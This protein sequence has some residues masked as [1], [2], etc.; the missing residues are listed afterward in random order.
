[1]QLPRCPAGTALVTSASL[2]HA[3]SRVAVV[4]AVATTVTG[5][6]GWLFPVLHV[7]CK[8]HPD[9]AFAQVPDGDL[10]PAFLGLPSCLRGDK[11][12]KTSPR[13]HMQV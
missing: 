6:L 5:P 9:S 4:A 3:Q 2:P 11:C 10:S 13:V 1:M 7:T 8:Q 12:T